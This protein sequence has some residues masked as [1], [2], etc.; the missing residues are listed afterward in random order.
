MK[1]REVHIFGIMDN[2]KFR[3]C[4]RCGVRHQAP[5]GKKCRLDL[6]IH[7]KQVIDNML[8]QEETHP[9][10]EDSD[11]LLAGD[12]SGRGEKLSGNENVLTLS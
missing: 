5:T 11:L 6:E 10:N 2:K 3:K 9:A 4:T 8:F 7:D 12:S 1:L